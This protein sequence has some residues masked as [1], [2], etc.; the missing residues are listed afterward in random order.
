MAKN[1]LTLHNIFG[2]PLLLESFRLCVRTNGAISLLPINLVKLVAK[3]T[4]RLSCV[5][6]TH[7]PTIKRIFSLSNR[8]KMVWAHTIRFRANMVYNKTIRY[9]TNINIISNPVSTSISFPKVKSTVPITVK[10]AIPLPTRGRL[11][12]LAF[13]TLDF[14]SCCSG[15][16]VHLYYL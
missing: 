6:G 12:K 5:Y 14:R 3:F 2:S 1:R 9:V 8:T 11:S 13:K 15:H 7:A 4:M 10:W 16:N